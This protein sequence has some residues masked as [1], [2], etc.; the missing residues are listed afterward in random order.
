MKFILNRFFKAI[1][2]EAVVLALLCVWFILSV[3]PLP[4]IQYSDGYFLWIPRLS[5]AAK[6]ILSGRIPFWNEYQFCGTTLLSDGNTNIFNPAIILYLFMAPEWGYT[7][8]TIILFVILL[9]GTWLY[10]REKDFSK[11]A[12]IIG[13]IGYA[14]GG[15][16]IFWSLYHGMNIVLSLFPLLLFFLRRYEKTGKAGWKVFAFITAFFTFCGGFIQFSIIAALSIIIEG[17]ERFS[18]KDTARVLKT[19]LPVISLAFI[20]ALFSIIPTIETAIFSHRESVRYFK[21]LFPDGI[22][23]MSMTFW[24]TSL[25][26]HGYPNYFYFLGIVLISLAIFTVRRQ[27]KSVFSRPFFV[28]SFIFPCIIILIYSGVL[29]VNFQ[30]GIESDIWRGMFVFILALALLAAG[31]VETFMRRLDNSGTKA[32]PPIEFLFAGFI[33]IGFGICNFHSALNIYCIFDIIIIIC[34]GI[35]MILGFIFPIV[36]KERKS[37]LKVIFSVWLITL[38]AVN[39]FYVCSNDYL[40]VDTFKNVKVLNPW[41]FNEIPVESFSN[42]EGRYIQLGLDGSYLEDWG[43]YNKIR[44]LGGYGSFFPKPI[45]SRMKEDGILPLNFHAITHFKNNNVLDP[46]IM[47]RY[48]VLYL[49]KQKDHESDPLRLGWRFVMNNQDIVVYKNPKYAGRAYVVDRQGGIVRGAD[50]VKN[51]NSYVKISLNAHEGETLILADSWFPGWICYDNGR[52]AVGFDAR[53][54][55]GYT[56]KTGGYHEIEWIYLPKT[57]IVSAIISFIGIVVFLLMIYREKMFLRYRGGAK[58]SN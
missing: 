16:I 43:I 55:R 31:A 18:F 48:G 38:M 1:G 39:I 36:F 52:K 21:G 11:E 28:Y 29:P 35:L 57:F 30:F 3:S 24:G 22:S 23:L 14:C 7:C 26:R 49:I 44:P 20:S 5:Y 25:D 32:F 40:S 8:S 9:A 51:T 46:D 19:R 53:G 10:F 34:L 41:E 12:A 54:F 4:F 58:L 13:T 37:K 56:I 47:A 15:Q 45:F 6:E 2:F 17:I 33:S 50:I 27:Y 42:K